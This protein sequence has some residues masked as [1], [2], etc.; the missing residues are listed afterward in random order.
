MTPEGLI[1]RASRHEPKETMDRLAAAVT[2]ETYGR[3]FGFERMMD[4]V[5]AIVGRV[6]SI[7]FLAQRL[8]QA[9]EQVGFVFDDQDSHALF[10][11][12]TTRSSPALDSPEL[13]KA[14]P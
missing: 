4:T 7:P 10:A 11:G 8:G 13:A 12:K 3:A 5:G 1:V 14:Q 9:R 2:K 6:H